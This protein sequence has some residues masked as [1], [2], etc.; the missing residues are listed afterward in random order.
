MRHARLPAILVDNK[1]GIRTSLEQAAIADDFQKD[2]HVSLS[3]ELTAEQELV[4]L[5]C[6][7]VPK[8]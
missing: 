1:S 7:A 3:L 4:L 6:R 5:L 8:R 2:A